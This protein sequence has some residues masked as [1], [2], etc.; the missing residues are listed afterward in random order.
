MY[1]APRAATVVAKTVGKLYCLDRL[2]FSE[3]VKT[4]AIKKRELYQKVMDKV[5]IFSELSQYER[6]QFYDVL[7]SEKYSDQEYIIHQGDN[8]NQFYIVVDGKLVAEKKEDGECNVVFEYKEGDYF[9]ELALLHDQPRQA[10]VKAVGKVTVACIQREAFKR[11]LGS[12]ED[13]LK[14]NQ[15]RYSN[16]QQQIAA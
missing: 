9:G 3:I 7:K 5:E 8:G 1:D 10:S 12:L 15:E 2:A 11:L 14:R 13:I 4:A 16:Y 6:E